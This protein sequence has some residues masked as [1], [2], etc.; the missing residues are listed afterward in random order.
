MLTKVLLS[1]LGLIAVF[2]FEL[3]AQTKLD[4]YP[5]H[6]EHNEVASTQET[7]NTTTILL[8]Y[9][10][11]LRDF[12][13]TI[14]LAHHD[15]IV[16]QQAWGLANIEYRV[17]NEIDTRFNVASISKTFTAVAVLQL[18]EQGKLE[19]HVP[20]GTY[21][22]DYP[23][24]PIRDRVTIHQ[25]LS[26]TSGLQ[27]FYGRKF[28]SAD[29]L[30]FNEVADFVPLFVQDTLAFSPGS[31]YKYS[32]SG[33]VLLGLII[34]A[35]TGS[36]YYD[37]LQEQ[38]FGPAGMKSSLAMRPDSV[39]ANK[40]SGYT[41]LWGDQAYLS[42]NDYYL[43]KA[44]PAGSHYAT[45]YDL[46]LFSKALQNDELLSK[47]TRELMQT[48]KVKGY[49]THLGYGIDIDQR[50]SELILGHSGGWFGVRTEWMCFPESG[51]S[52][53]VLSNIDDDGKTGASRV[54][55]D[56]KTIIAGQ[57]G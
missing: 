16:R 19:L 57:K 38:V 33:F 42:R 7:K 1:V 44:S 34:E 6:V 35:V 52:I 2:Q 22:P 4:Q 45:A 21:L 46:W 13:G 26:H 17:A 51:Y 15:E 39:M 30:Q 48:P 20:I 9:L 50:Y 5:R 55:E 40:A 56:L 32:G 47:E 43:A 10:D 37:Y 11:T 8:D 41:R 23:N 49:N 31:S 29:K 54:I 25:I 53:V 24:E 3:T 18:F 36:T 14:L 28:L 27:P 12:S